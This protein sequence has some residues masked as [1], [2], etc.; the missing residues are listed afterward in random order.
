VNF[1]RAALQIVPAFFLLALPASAVEIRYPQADL[2]G[3]PSMSDEHGKLIADGELTQEV[4][5]SQLFVHSVWRFKDGRIVTEDDQLS[6]K[7]ELRQV[8]FRWVERRG[9]R[10]LRRIDV[11]FL[12]GKATVTHLGGEKPESWT[13]KLDLPAGKAFTGYSTALAVSQL[14]DA[15]KDKDA[16]RELTF[17]AFTPKPRTVTLEISRQQDDR[18]LAA[19]RDIEADLFTL[20]PSL[21][22]PVSL[23]AGAKD[24]HLWFTHA[25]PPALLRAEENLVEK[26]DP[27]IYI[28]VIPK[29]A[30][31]SQPAARKGKPAPR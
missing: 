13:E 22:F 29:G 23:F 19:G 15:L 12:T 16:R 20:H 10:D 2:H 31:L 1:A 26:D 18:L 30:A 5:G 24:A 11:D 25:P 8:S 4:K 28:D 9:E 27:V 6:V 21:P 14:R 17:I 3:F 7:P